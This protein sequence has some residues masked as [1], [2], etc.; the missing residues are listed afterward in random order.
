MFMQIDNKKIYYK[1]TGTGPTVVF[2]H[3]F[4]GNHIVWSEQEAYLAKKGYQAITFDHIGHGQSQGPAAYTV[5]E[6]IDDM[7]QLIKK[8]ALKSV[9]LVGHSM[10]AS[11]VWGLM[12]Y[13]PEIDVTKII[14]IDQTPK[15]LNDTNWNYGW[16]HDKVRLTPVNFKK[17]LMQ[18]DH[19]KETLNGIDR[20]VW[21]KLYPFKQEYPFEREK[22]IPLLLDH[23]QKDWRETVYSINIPMLSVS[24]SKSPYFKLGYTTEMQKNNNHI[25]VNIVS[26]AGH[27]IMAE[28]PDEFNM[29]MS[30]FLEIR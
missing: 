16:M 28:K 29:L 11:I 27:D 3:G 1:I 8:L 5:K 14:T 26:D 23:V 25:K 2:C 21:S 18:N 19:I 9:I 12:F 20:R 15:M 7:A 22:N 4:G 30:R 10:G 13:H 24:S 6:V 17:V